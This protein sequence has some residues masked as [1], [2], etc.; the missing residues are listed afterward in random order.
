MNRVFVILIITIAC[1]LLVRQQLKLGASWNNE[2]GSITAIEGDGAT[3]VRGE[4]EYKASVGD[5][6][7]RGEIIKTADGW[8]AIECDGTKIALAKNTEVQLLS[9]DYLEDGA[10]VKLIGGRIVTSQPIEIT[11][12][13]IDIASSDRVSV[14]NYSWRGEVDIIPI[15]SATTVVDNKTLGRLPVSFP[16]TWVESERRL[17]TSLEPFNFE[18]SSETEFYKWAE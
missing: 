17:F 14:V 4:H 3:R 2:V 18:N 5:K 9:A 11:T 15:D 8:V 13:W 1:V 10:R 6:L 12:P 7:R 16:S